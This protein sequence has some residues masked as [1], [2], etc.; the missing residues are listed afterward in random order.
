MLRAWRFF[1]L[2]CPAP[3]RGMLLCKLS[4]ERPC[5]EKIL[6]FTCGFAYERHV[7]LCSPPGT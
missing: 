5:R 7:H 6:D 4:F 2:A 3:S 1:L